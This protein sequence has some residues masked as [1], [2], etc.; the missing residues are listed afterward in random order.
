MLK[1]T[2]RIGSSA[3]KAAA[4]NVAPKRRGRPPKVRPST[5][6]AM[7]TN[8]DP[9]MR[10]ILDLSGSDRTEILEGAPDGFRLRW[11][12]ESKVRTR[13]SQ[14]YTKVDDPKVKTHFD[15]NYMPAEGYDVRK[16]NKGGLIL[17]KI[18]ETL[19]KKRDAIKAEKVD[20]QSQSM[21]SQHLSSMRDAGGEVLGADDAFVSG[22]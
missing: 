1:V 11:C 20:R 14:G 15:G 12:E 17:M 7:K 18:P 3:A 19:A 22:L 9:D 2:N 4:A 16:A 8:E 6:E 10:F 21:E 5:L 13:E